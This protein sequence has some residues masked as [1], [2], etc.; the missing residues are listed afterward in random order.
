MNSEKKYYKLKLCNHYKK[1]NKCPKGSE[2]NYA[3]GEKELRDF[4]KEDCINGS[5]CFKE[6]CKFNHPSGWNYKDNLKICEFFKNGYCINED[7][8]KFKHVKE[9]EVEE[10]NNYDNI[11][12]KENIDISNKNEFP[13]LKGNMISDTSNISNI[14]EDVLGTSSSDLIKNENLQDGIQY[15]EIN[16]NENININK[17]NNS[18]PNIEILVNVIEYDDKDNMLNMNKDI[19]HEKEKNNFNKSKQTENIEDLIN[20]L[21]YNFLEFSR[22][23]KNN[24]DE[25]FIEDKYIYSVNMKLGLNKII[26]EIELFKNNY[27]DIMNKED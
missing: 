11:E 19:N 22:K 14:N 5:K 26:S 15:S 20:K 12:I 7:N 27:Q 18:S 1:N 6:D 24:I 9:D 3:H 13:S 16:K 25:L 2:C 10:I 21:Q 17:E 23:I 4:K 8:C